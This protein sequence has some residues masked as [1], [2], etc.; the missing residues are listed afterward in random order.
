MTAQQANK[1]VALVFA[2][3]KGDK[4][5]LRLLLMENWPW[6]KAI[7]YN[8]L[9]KSD[10]I[11]DVLQNICLRVITNIKG[12]RNP[13]RF[14][15]WLAV[16]AKNEALS[17]RQKQKRKPSL[18][19]LLQAQENSNK[20]EE[21]P[22]EQMVQNEQY[23][24]VLAAIEALPEKYKEVMLLKYAKDMTYK[25]I[26]EIIEIPI[27]TVQIRL[28]RARRMVYEKITANPIQNVSQD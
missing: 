9:G 22:L 26:G 13:R 17:N 1:E 21:N 27:T 7:V 19:Q 23:S 12:L 25:D 11:D 18:P 5:A 15:P 10:E 6:L 3:R 8:I 4:E 24:K 2:S 16:L 28:V 20:S 14:R